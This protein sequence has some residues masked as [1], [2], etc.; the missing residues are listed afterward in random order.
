L[1]HQAQGGLEQ[2]AE[3]L[4]SDR[5]SKT[6]SGVLLAVQK[7]EALPDRANVNEEVKISEE[8]DSQVSG[9]DSYEESES[10]EDS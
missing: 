4:K 8:D 7:S 6:K 10:A 2:I 5:V 3:E 1:K 9:D